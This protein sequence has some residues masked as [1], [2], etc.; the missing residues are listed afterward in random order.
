MKILKVQ[1]LPP[2]FF[3]TLCCQINNGENRWDNLETLTIM[4][5]QDTDKQNKK[6]NTENS[7]SISYITFW[8]GFKECNKKN[9]HQKQTNNK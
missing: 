3:F 2:L 4:G 6:H 9:P 7:T 1:F 8:K 5:T